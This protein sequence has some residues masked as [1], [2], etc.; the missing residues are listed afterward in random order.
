VLL[1]LVLVGNVF[2]RVV[3]GLG[4]DRGRSISRLK[5]VIDVDVERGDSI[6]DV[7][8]QVD[9]DVHLHRLPLLTYIVV[10]GFLVVLDD[11]HQLRGVYLTQL[12]QP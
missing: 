1:Q 6:L 7:D 8:I 5:V 2:G 9:H 10:A 4:S 11:L 3:G 12:L